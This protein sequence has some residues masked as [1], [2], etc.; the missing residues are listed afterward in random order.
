MSKE[1]VPME[2]RSLGGLMRFLGRGRPNF[3]GYR[4]EYPDCP[5]FT[6]FC[7]DDVG[8]THRCIG[9]VVIRRSLW[10]RRSYPEFRIRVYLRGEISWLAKSETSSYVAAKMSG[11]HA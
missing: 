8:F 10:L 3:E 6:G 4:I 2:S 11:L 7:D 9:L 1:R 5:A